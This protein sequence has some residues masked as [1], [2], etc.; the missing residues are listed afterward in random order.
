MAKDLEQ[1]R[2]RYSNRT[3]MATRQAAQMLLLRP[4]L[5]RILKIRVHGKANIA[6]L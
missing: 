5:Q 2:K 1:Q 6:N 4:A 3:S